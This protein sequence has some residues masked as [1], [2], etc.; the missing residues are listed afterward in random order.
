MPDSAAAAAH[1]TD[2]QKHVTRAVSN[3]SCPAR[4]RGGAVSRLGAT[5][6]RPR[7]FINR[8]RRRPSSDP[9]RALSTIPLCFIISAINGMDLWRAIS[10]VPP[11]Y[12]N[13][14]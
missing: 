5:R 1:E 8:T 12:E 4:A 6:C 9:R 13:K 7:A 3:R 14:Y 11:V 10:F 2:R